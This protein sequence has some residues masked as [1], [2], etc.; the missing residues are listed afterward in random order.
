MAGLIPNAALAN[1]PSLLL[2]TYPQT[3]TGWAGFQAGE[4]T[5]HLLHRAQNPLSRKEKAGERE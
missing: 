1:P 2:G 5:F 3:F 4:P